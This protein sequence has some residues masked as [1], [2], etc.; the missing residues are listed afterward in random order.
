VPARRIKRRSWRAA[1]ASGGGELGAGDSGAGGEW[2]GM[3][4]R[5]DEWI[6][7]SGMEKKRRV[8]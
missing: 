7:M 1:G 3:D 4:W 8:Y 6:G 5:C 2:M